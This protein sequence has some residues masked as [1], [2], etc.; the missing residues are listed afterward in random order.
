MHSTGG[1]YILIRVS[2]DWRTSSQRCMT[3]AICK[4]VDEDYA[5]TQET[6]S[7]AAELQSE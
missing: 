5:P 4:V 3:A 1:Q 6:R 2:I 7:L